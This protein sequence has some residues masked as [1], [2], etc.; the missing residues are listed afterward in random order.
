MNILNTI[1]LLKLSKYSQ[2]STATKMK[3]WQIHSYGNIQELQ[4]TNA[5]I[6][7][8]ENPKDLLIKVNAA[9][10]NPIDVL[11]TKGYGKTLI[12]LFR[13]HDLEFPLTLGRDFSGIIIN[14]GQDVSNKF[15]VGDNV[16]GVIPIHK[17]G[18]HAEQVIANESHIV[19]QP[20]HLT[21]IEATAT[22]YAA[23]TAWSALYITG[24]FALRKPENSRIL[25]L[26]AS[27]G[28]GTVAVQML[29]SQNATV[30]GTCS[31]DAVP[32]VQSL[33]VDRVFDYT[34]PN[35]NESISCEAKFDIILDCAKFGHT[36]I[37]NSWKYDRYVTL[38]SPLL[39]N[40]DSHGLVYGLVSSAYDLLS[41]NIKKCS[42]GQSVRW[43][44]FNPSEKGLQFINDL[45]QNNQVTP[46]IHKVFQF[47]ELPKAY[48]EL[49][50]GHIRGKIVIDMNK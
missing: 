14:K 26:G 25:V 41:A 16:C 36:N 4:L 34:K 30:M 17:Q 13:D 45:L 43:G 19:H 6:P 1:K 15:N 20:K 24:E 21:A 33:G 46:T 31:T 12:N 23:M 47:N 18:S 5:R 3:A 44:F 40:T 8:I 11:M 7:H 2:Y 32:L 9:S 35:F 48:E 37:P 39:I 22:L 28:V 38:N 49:N 50:A 27:G 29:K 42:S 10:V